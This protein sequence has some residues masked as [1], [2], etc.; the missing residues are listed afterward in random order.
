MRAEM[1]SMQRSI[2]GLVATF[3]SMAGSAEEAEPTRLGAML[4]SPLR[5]PPVAP[6]LGHRRPSPLL[7]AARMAARQQQQQHHH[8]PH[9]KQKQQKQQQ[10]Q[11]QQEQQQ[12]QQKQ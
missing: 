2:A 6:A 11:K 12:E 8:H 4:S 7:S 1:R 5:D 3:A 9:Q 10:Q